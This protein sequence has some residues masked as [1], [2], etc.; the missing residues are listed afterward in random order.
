MNK[1]SIDT[2]NKVN[3]L[4]N[5]SQEKIRSKPAETAKSGENKAAVQH[6][7]MKFSKR[8]AEVRGLS[9]RASKMA[10]VRSQLVDHFKNSISA[11]KYNPPASDISAALLSEEL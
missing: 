3:E 5:T 8:A 6:D 10:D 1:I 2:S 7:D 4:R 9:E 11:G